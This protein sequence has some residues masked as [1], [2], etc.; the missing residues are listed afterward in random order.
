MLNF[1]KVFISLAPHLGWQH[2]SIDSFKSEIAFF[3]LQKASIFQDYVL[4]N[5]HTSLLSSFLP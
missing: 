2:K 1:L 5:S 3:H 4:G